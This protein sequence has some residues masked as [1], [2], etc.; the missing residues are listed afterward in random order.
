MRA[1]HHLWRGEMCI[2]TAAS[3]ER[4]QRGGGR[5]A[6]GDAWT[7]LARPRE[8]RVAYGRCVCARRI[9]SF[10]KGKLPL[11]LLP[12]YRSTSPVGHTLNE[13][14]SP[15]PTCPAGT[16]PFS[17]VHM[18]RKFSVARGAVSGYK[19]NTIRPICDNDYVAMRSVTGLTKTLS[20]FEMP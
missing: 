14:E 6:E 12:T 19:A 3:Q 13:Y 16:T 10:I 7:Q 18:T 20:P 2:E 17:P 8:R 9:A 4:G 15:V 5:G 1:G 11:S